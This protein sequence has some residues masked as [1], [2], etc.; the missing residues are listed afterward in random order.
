MSGRNFVAIFETGIVQQSTVLGTAIGTVFNI[1]NTSTTTFGPLGSVGSGQ[2]IKDLTV[3][4]EGP[5]TIWISN[6]TVPATQAGIT[7][8][9]GMQVT[10]GGYS[11]TAAAGGVG[12]LYATCLVTT[13]T[14]TVITGMASVDPVA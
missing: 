11:V 10:L 13:G 5:G 4:N 8:N 12:N 6:G 1:N 7:M 3:V 2:V 9:P 14:A